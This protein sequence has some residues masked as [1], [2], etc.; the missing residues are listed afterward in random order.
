VAAARWIEAYA[1][2]HR[3]LALTLAQEGSVPGFGVF[4]ASIAPEAAAE[5]VLRSAPA[6]P[7]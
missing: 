4:R 1:A 2:R 3:G 6:V 5:R 7:E